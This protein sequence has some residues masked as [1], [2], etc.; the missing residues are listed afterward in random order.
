LDYR[1]ALDYD[2]KED[3]MVYGQIAT[4]Y[5]A[6]GN[7]ARPMYPSQMYSFGPE[8]LTNYEVG[9]K[10]T[11]FNQLRLNASV[12][13]NDYKDIQLLLTECYWAPENERSPC[14]SQDNIGDAEVTGFELEG[15]WRPTEAFSVDFSYAHI[16]FEYTRLTTLAG[17]E[18]DSDTPYTPENKFSLGAQYRFGLG[19]G[20]GTL[21]PRIDASF[22]DDLTTTTTYINQYTTIENYTLVNARLTW[23]SEDAKWEAALECTNLTDKYYHAS[24]YDMQQGEG[25][26]VAQ[27]GR[28]REFA[29]T[30][31]RY[32]F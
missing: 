3:F 1:V 10:N 26:Y 21:T 20:W 27:P 14:A 15:V 13:F 22:Q 6:G 25:R 23:G 18:I 30:I 7:N 32:W 17:V 16:E 2:F 19:D 11:L 5:R 8:E 12:F 4:G 28:P 29:F 24:I 31:K 9:V